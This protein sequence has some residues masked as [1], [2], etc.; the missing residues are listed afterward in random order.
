L[1][2]KAQGSKSGQKKM[3][4]RWITWWTH[5]MSYKEFLRTRKLKRGVVS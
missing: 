3:T 4:R 5:T 2:R 1:S